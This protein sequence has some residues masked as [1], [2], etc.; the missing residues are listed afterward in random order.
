VCTSSRARPPAAPVGIGGSLTSTF[1]SSWSMRSKVN[2]PRLVVV[3]RHGCAPAW[4]MTWRRP[5]DDSPAIPP[6]RRSL[7]TGATPT[8]GNPQPPML[9]RPK[10]HNDKFRVTP[11]IG[12]RLPR[13]AAI[14]AASVLARFDAAPP[15]NKRWARVHRYRSSVPPSAPSSTQPGNTGTTSA[16]AQREPKRRAERPPTCRDLPSGQWGRWEKVR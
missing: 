15:K 11:F 13:S 3:C 6:P 14:V 5:L 16:R 12:A 9:G 8:P 1:S 2:R 10:L 4:C 7:L